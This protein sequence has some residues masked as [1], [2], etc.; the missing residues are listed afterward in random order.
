[1][2]Y[3]M[4]AGTSSVL[5]CFLHWQA[6][7]VTP[8]MPASVSIIS[9]RSQNT[10]CICALKTLR[11]PVYLINPARSYKYKPC[12]KLGHFWIY[13]SESIPSRRAMSRV[14]EKN[15]NW[16]NSN[17]SILCPSRN[18]WI[19]RSTHRNF[20][21]TYSHGSLLIC[22]LMIWMSFSPVLLQ[23]ISCQGIELARGSCKLKIQFKTSWNVW[24]IYV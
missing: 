12:I 6:P 16:E 13:D 9:Q 17:C 7:E 2:Q 14:S 3:K 1:M 23:L 24:M 20:S 8:P 15:K 4:K 10:G 11:K 5:S 18:G 21:L 19:F 22:F